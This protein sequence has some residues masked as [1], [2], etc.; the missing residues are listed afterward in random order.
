MPTNTLF[1]KEGLC[2][3]DLQYGINRLTFWDG[4]VYYLYIPETISVL[5][6]NPRLL[7]SIHG[8]SGRKKETKGRE[9]I[10]K[11]AERWAGLAER[12]GWVVLAPQFDGKRFNRDWQRLSL[13][14]LRT[15]VRLHDLIRETGRLIPPLRTDRIF[16]FGFSAGGQ[17]VHRYLAFH[18]DRVERAVSA[19]SGWYLWPDKK[20]PYPVGC[21]PRS[22]REG[23]RPNF[24][25]LCEKPLLVI[26]GEEDAMQGAF[27]MRYK[28]YDLQ[29]TQGEGRRKR[30]ENWYNAVKT[31]SLKHGV[32]FELSFRTLPHTKHRITKK[33]VEIAGDYLSVPSL[34]SQKE[35]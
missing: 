28:Q 18:P 19:G 11:S 31:F 14:G 2:S 9:I 4:Q 32:P 5:K 22:F 30:A 3:G 27:R 21:D 8:F 17:F 15:D 20:L 34:S 24:R 13:F 16:Y 29:M 12:N 7:V 6:N 10:R 35:R 25:A 26:A 33:L 1:F 23:G